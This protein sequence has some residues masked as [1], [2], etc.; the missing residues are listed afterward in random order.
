[1]ILGFSLGPYL[2][3]LIAS[4]LSYSAA[5]VIA[6]LLLIT[7]YFAGVR[8]LPGEPILPHGH[9]RAH[10]FY[11]LKSLVHNRTLL[12]CWTA[13][14]G[15]S[16]IS[17]MFMAFFPLYLKGLGMTAAGVG[18]LFSL[19]SVANGAFRLPAGWVLDRFGRP[20]TMVFSGLIV[21]ALL[22]QLFVFVEDKVVLAALSVLFGL[23]IAF[24]FNSLGTT[25]ARESPLEL[26][27]MAM[28]FYTTCFYSG[29]LISSFLMGYV[30]EAAGYRMG[31]GL[32]SA[33]G[34]ILA[35]PGALLIAKKKLP[36]D[37]TEP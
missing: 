9:E 18:L 17:G 3:G 4:S 30:V 24:T 25:V 6:G 34:L 1:M 23:N 2:G 31:F 16:F 33:I 5:F 37:A 22:N 20:G 15:G 32:S 14:F 36:V 26:K 11:A 19:R 8:L 27:G 35:L 21:L 13:A 10:P 28:G 12:G 7:V 29:A